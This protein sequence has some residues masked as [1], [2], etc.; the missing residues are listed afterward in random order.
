MLC[1]ALFG[2]GR[3]AFDARGDDAAPSDAPIADAPRLPLDFEPPA[4]LVSLSDPTLLDDDATLTDDLLEI[5]FASD[6]SNNDDIWVASRLSPSLPFDP[7]QPVS[8]FNT[9]FYDQSPELTGDGLTVFFVSDRTGGVG[10]SDIYVATRT[11]RTAPW[12]APTLVAELSSPTEDF[13][14]TPA[15][16]LQLVYASDREGGPD[17]LDLYFATRA[18]ANQPWVSSPRI[19]ELDDGA[20]ERTPFP[21]GT[22]IYFASDRTG[23]NDIYL[24][25]G[26][27]YVATP[28]TSLNTP[29]NEEDPWLSPDGTR[30]FFAS[31]RDGSYDLFEAVAR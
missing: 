1:V 20:V 18:A 23:N 11:T 8:L 21:R 7:P 28:V 29:A 17:E 5:Y 9:A 12:S 3:I 16:A 31:D 19:T 26:P 25:T 6:R 22:A 27:P 30:M 24:A 4:K 14:A 2:C 13:S 15:S 10:G